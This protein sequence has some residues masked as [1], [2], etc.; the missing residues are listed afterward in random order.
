MRLILLAIIAVIMLV[1][2][3]N[4]YN[5]Y[6]EFE[7]EYY[8]ITLE[9]SRSQEEYYMGRLEVID[10]YEKTGELSLQQAHDMHILREGNKWH[11]RE[12]GVGVV[13]RQN[14]EY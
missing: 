8:A 2:V 12:L 4:Y 14:T 3:E 9:N 6:P 5:V 1:A 13:M 10:R 7:R 11:L